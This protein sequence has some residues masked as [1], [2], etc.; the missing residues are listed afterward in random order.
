[1]PYPSRRRTVVCEVCHIAFEVKASQ[2]AR[3][4]CSWACKTVW[5]QSTRIDSTCQHCSITFTTYA[6]RRQKYC[7]ISCGITARN[8]TPHN[9]AYHRDISGAKNPMY[10]KG[11]SGSANPMSGRTGERHPAWKGGRKVRKD[12][13]VLVL[14]PEGHPYAISTGKKNTQTKYVLEHR[15]VMEQHLG[16]YLLPEEVVHHHDHNPSNNCIDNLELCASQGAHITQHHEEMAT[17]RRQTRNRRRL[18]S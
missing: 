3:R 4:F 7:S 12:G 16:R 17:R 18:E 9:P 8:L 6:S 2:T 1:M 5:G 15:L 10:G 13:Y 11:L 14:A